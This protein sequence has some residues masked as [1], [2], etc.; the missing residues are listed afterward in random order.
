MEVGWKEIGGSLYYA[1]EV[2]GTTYG[3][4]QKGWTSVYGIPVHFDE[5]TYKLDNLNPAEVL[6]EVANIIYEQKQGV[7]VSAYI[8]KAAEY[9]AKYAYLTAALVQQQIQMGQAA[10][11]AQAIVAN[12]QMV[13]PNM[14]VQAIKNGIWQ[15]NAAGNMTYRPLGGAP[16]TGW[17]KIDDGGIERM[18][19]FNEI[20]EMQE[21]WQAIGGK[22]YYFI[23]NGFKAYAATGVVNIGGID[24]Y[25]DETTCELSQDNP[26]EAL[27]QVSLLFNR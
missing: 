15:L 1:D 14:N 2:P 4:V 25:F 7:P 16:V 10:A 27:Q 17:T 5:S 26:A 21:G 18:Y 9:A 13:T 20:G 22:V 19:Y 24:L 8:A 11:D 6:A 12:A 3:I 23:K